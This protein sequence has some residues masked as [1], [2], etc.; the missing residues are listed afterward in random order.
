[1][2]TGSPIRRGSVSWAVESGL[3][4][5]ASQAAV[6]LD[7]M[8]YGDDIEPAAV[9]ALAELLEKRVKNGNG[10]STTRSIDP[11]SAAILRQA[12]S[13]SYGRHLTESGEIQRTTGELADE[14]RKVADQVRT[15]L[16]DHDSLER[17]RK[18]CLDLS[19]AAQSYRS[20]VFA[21]RPVHPYRR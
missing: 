9:Y 17:L 4:F 10:S 12:Y 5:L 3:P 18:Y 19:E 7:C 16:E 20:N 11:S 15:A 14:L 2:L 6:E 21:P 8:S 1:M 13:S